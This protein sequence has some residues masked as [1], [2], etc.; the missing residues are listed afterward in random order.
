MN[1]IEISREALNNTEALIKNYALSD[2]KL[3]KIRDRKERRELADRFTVALNGM[4]MLMSELDRT[5]AIEL[6]DNYNI[7][8]NVEKAMDRIRNNNSLALAY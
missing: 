1:K 2:K 3:H 7:I 8:N 5:R 4:F 6:L